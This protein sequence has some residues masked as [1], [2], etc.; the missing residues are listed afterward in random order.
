MWRFDFEFICFSYI[1]QKI[2]ADNEVITGLLNQNV[3]TT[4]KRWIQQQL[5]SSFTTEELLGRKHVYFTARFI[6][7]C[8]CVCV[9][10][11]LNVTFKESVGQF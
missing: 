7:V 1:L 2:K 5:I 4:N 10:F 3:Q 6:R 11:A 9:F 8:V